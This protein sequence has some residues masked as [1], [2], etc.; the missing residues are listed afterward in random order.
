MQFLPTTATILDC[1]IMEFITLHNYILLLQIDAMLNQYSKTNEYG[2]SCFATCTS[3]PNSTLGYLLFETHK[4]QLAHQLI[5]A[6]ATRK[7]QLASSR[8]THKYQLPYE[9]VE[10]TCNS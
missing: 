7:Y 3:Q 6:R 2:L 5:I 4:Y 10:R 9:L 1:G 8:G